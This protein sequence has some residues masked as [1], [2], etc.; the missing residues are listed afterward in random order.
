MTKQKMNTDAIQIHLQQ[1]N[2]SAVD[3]WQ[4]RDGKLYKQFIFGDFTR[5]FAWMTQV[6]ISAE[7][8]DHHPEWFN[9]YNRV[10]VELTTHDANGLTELDFELASKMELAL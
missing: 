4:I 8:M 1:L 5:A 7:K 3:T 9:V 10:S 6:A 2:D